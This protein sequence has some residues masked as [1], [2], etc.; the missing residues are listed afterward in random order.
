MNTEAKVQVSDVHGRDQL[1][2]QMLT[3]ALF[4]TNKLYG[5]CLKSANLH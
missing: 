1:S 3:L 4:G 2:N 5:N